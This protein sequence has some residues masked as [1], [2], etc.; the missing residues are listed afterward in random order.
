MSKIKDKKLEILP[1]LEAFIVPLQK[2]EYAQLERNI[3]EEGCRDPL[4]VWSREK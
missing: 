1:E 4:I 3:I 2:E